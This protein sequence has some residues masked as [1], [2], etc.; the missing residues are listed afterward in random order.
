MLRY[1]DFFNDIK[2]KNDTQKNLTILIFKSHLKESIKKKFHDNRF[3]LI[4]I[5]D[6]LISIY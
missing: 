2:L 6:N 4:V 3:D 5:S 1:M